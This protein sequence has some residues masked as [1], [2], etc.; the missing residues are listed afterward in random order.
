MSASLAHNAWAREAATESFPGQDGKAPATRLFVA[1]SASHAGKSTV[2]LG[3]LE[4]AVERYGADA[5]AYCKAATQDERPD[6]VA[7]WCAARGV[8]CVSGADCPI[9]Y[10]AGFTR[11]FLDGGAYASEDWLDRAAATVARL[12]DGRRVVVIDGVGYPAVGSVCGTSNADVAARLKAPV[13]VVCKSGV[14]GAIDEVNFA[15]AFFAAR[16]VPVLGCVLNKAATT[17]FYAATQIL[18]PLRA[19]FNKSRRALYG[20][21]RPPASKIED[22]A[23]SG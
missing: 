12:A 6:A 20:V 8:E 18:A 5:V 16:D 19:Y 15:A 4:A 1:G 21:V 2:C 7:R 3:V 23:R 22:D 17:G 13:C 14:G 10:Y 11:A 9:V